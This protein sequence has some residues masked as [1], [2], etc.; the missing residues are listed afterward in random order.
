MTTDDATPET[1]RPNG[2]DL[3]PRPGAQAL[4]WAPYIVVALCLTTALVVYLKGGPVELAVAM[5]LAAAG[6]GGGVQISIHI[7]R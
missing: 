1:I 4:A 7:R 2:T 3:A 5:V 6:L